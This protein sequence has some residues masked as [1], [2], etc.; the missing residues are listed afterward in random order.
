MFCQVAEFRSVN[1][2][3]TECVFARWLVSEKEKN[4][5]LYEFWGALFPICYRRT[6]EESAEIAESAEST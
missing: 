5:R 6:V 1:P 2:Y 4:A 3:Q